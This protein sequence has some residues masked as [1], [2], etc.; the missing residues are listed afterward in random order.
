MKMKLG[1]I[2]LIGLIGLIAGVSAMGQTTNTSDAAPV[3][4]PNIQNAT[5]F[6]ATLS[7]WLAANNPA[8][9]NLYGDKELELE[10]GA[11]YSQSTGEAGIKLDVTEWGLF[12]KNWGVGASVVEGNQD[13]KSGT[14][15][16]W[17]HLDYRKI[18][19]NVAGKLYLGPGY[20]CERNKPMG[21]IGLQVEYRWTAHLGAY[22]GVGYALEG[23]KAQD[24]GLIAGAGLNYA[25]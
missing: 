21:V 11:V 19:G 5:D 10:L 25:F 2:G 13:G 12:A 15:G 24:R 23:S 14:A 3:A 6:F 22:A 8:L 4:A 17:A 18:I 16:T 7:Q 20:D 9:T 1:K